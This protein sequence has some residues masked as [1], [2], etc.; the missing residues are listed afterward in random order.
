MEILD[1]D[2]WNDDGTPKVP[3]QQYMRRL[4]EVQDLEAIDPET[5][6]KRAAEQA[7]AMRL[8]RA[9][10]QMQTAPVIGDVVHFWDDENARCRAAIVMEIEVGHVATL[11][12]H[13]PHE[14]FQ[15]WTCDHDEDKGQNTWHWAETA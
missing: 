5:A 11:R 6:E 4:E 10:S 8:Y 9:Q 3:S 2:L 7:E 12:V 1:P 15:D 13:V 14:A